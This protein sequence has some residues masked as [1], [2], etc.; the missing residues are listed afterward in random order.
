MSSQPGKPNPAIEAAV[1]RIRE[2][3]DR[4]V[5][6]A[7]QGDEESLKTYERSRLSPEDLNKIDAYEARTRNRKTIRDRISALRR[8]QS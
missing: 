5:R 3:N 2:L 1:E 4:I 8:A 6:T 7:K